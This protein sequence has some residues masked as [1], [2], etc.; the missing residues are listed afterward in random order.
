MPSIHS[1]Y[2]RGR[3]IVLY[4]GDCTDL[5]K[6]IP[7]NSVD[8]VVSS[9]PYCMGKEYESSTSLHD[10]R[11]QHETLFPTLVKLLK[12]G[13]SICWQVGVHVDNGVVTPLDY[14][15]QT[16]A[17]QI[18]DLVL[19]NRIIWHFGHGLH[20]NKRFSG[21]HETILWFS[22]GSP[23]LFSLDAVRVKQKY[24]GKR[25]YK[26]EHKGRHSGN[27]LGK[28]PSDVWDIPNV[29]AQHVEKTDHPCQFP[30]AIPQRLIRALTEPG[31]TV[32]DPFS[33]SGTTAVAAVL[34]K[35]RFIGAEI[36][37]RYCKLA[38][39]RIAG[40]LKG[41]LEVRP[42]DEPVMAPNPNSAVARDPFV[43]PIADN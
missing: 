41:T 31:D 33:G 30:V 18:S 28:N 3:R 17:S 14:E 4:P 37:K 36:S 26:G 7:P 10:F 27:P 32:L 42:L 16:V 5:L 24:P 13:G 23:N 12:P 39:S 20:C 29:K 35:R 15:V 11:T 40:A 19:R 38:R 1:E 6:S 9:P 43:H 8:L 22:K 25:A 21:R 34:E 2:R